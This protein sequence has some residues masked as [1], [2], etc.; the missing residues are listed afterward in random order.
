MSHP[1]SEGVGD[2]AINIQPFFSQGMTF[3][4]RT[5]EHV[6]YLLSGMC[7]LSITLIV[8]IAF[9]FRRVHLMCH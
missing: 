4:F 7:L 8:L 3:S 1:I 9:Y 5:T 2:K 6:F